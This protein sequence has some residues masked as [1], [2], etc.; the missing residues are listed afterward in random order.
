MTSHSQKPVRPF[1]GWHMLAI[2]VGAFGVIIAVNV[3]LAWKAI[4]TFPGLDVDN[5]YV[6]SQTFD[7]EKAAQEA[8]GWTLSQG[9]DSAKRQLR[10]GFVDR[11]GQNATLRDLSVLVGRP[12]EAAQDQRP[13]LQQ[14][15]DGAYVAALDLPKG[16]WMLQIEGHA[17]D[18]TYYHAWTSF[19]VR[20]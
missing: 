14:E 9:Y 8:L 16:K 13:A 4:S 1:T 12:T 7:A 19:Y 17:Q 18:G 20:D 5:S 2:M 11:S 3:G 10:L 6:A 15:A